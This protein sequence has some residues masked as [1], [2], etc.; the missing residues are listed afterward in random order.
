ML[1]KDPELSWQTQRRFSEQGK[2][3]RRVLPQSLIEL[4]YRDH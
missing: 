4:Y 3:I 2:A 1:L